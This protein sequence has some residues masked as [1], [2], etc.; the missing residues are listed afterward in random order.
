MTLRAAIAILL[1]AG[2][3]ACAT[4]GRHDGDT[5]TIAG[6]DY[7]L[8]HPVFPPDAEE[9]ERRAFAAPPKC[10]KWAGED[11]FAGCKRRIAKVNAVSQEY[12]PLR[13]YSSIEG[14]RNTLVSDADMQELEI[15][16][17]PLS[18]RVSF[19]NRNVSVDALL[20]AFSKEDDQD[21]HLILQDE[22]CKSD[23]CRM[24]VEVSALMP[25]CKGQCALS[26]PR[27]AFEQQISGGAQPQSS[28]TVFDPPV[29]VHVEGSLFFDVD[30][31]GGT[32]GPMGHRSSSSWE[33]H[34]V[35]AIAPR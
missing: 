32:V 27:A 21:Y 30:H 23:G 13:H 25:S 10:S 1:A 9:I 22:G 2:L 35:T 34:P 15:P 29:P 33:I 28:Y 20:Y 11:V 7:K 17:D 16:S 19:E 24:N 5:V 6:K 3:A 8:L 31:K 18:D 26:V 12:Y 4:T 14:L